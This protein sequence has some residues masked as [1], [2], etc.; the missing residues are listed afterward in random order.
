MRRPVDE[1]LIRRFLRAFG[2]EAKEETRLYFTGGVTAVLHGW[3]ESTVDLD[4]RFFPEGDN[5]YRAIPELKESL[6][7]NIELAAPSDFI[8]E[9]PGWRDRSAFIAREGKVSYYHYDYYAQ[10]L[11]KIERGH[12]RDVEDVNHMIEDGLVEPDKARD[13]F[14]AIE[15]NLYRFPAV[16][17]RRFRERVAS[18]FRSHSS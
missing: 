12:D 11:A 15:P 5:L 17:P 10:A 14:Q 9:L 3:R 13:L 2:A 18:A 4:I 7:L 8:P 16:D 1:A 6:H